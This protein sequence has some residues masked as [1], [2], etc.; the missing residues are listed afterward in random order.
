MEKRHE[1]HIRLVTCMWRHFAEKQLI[2]SDENNEC[3][4]ISLKDLDVEKGKSTCKDK[5][6]NGHVQYEQ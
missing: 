1:Y 2:L 4:K 5:R 3:G 6:G